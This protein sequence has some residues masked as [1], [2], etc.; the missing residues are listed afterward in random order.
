M[1]LSVSLKT[2]TLTTDLWV[3]SNAVV[4]Q[5]IQRLGLDSLF[6]IASLTDFDLLELICNSNWLSAL[7][8]GAS[9]F[10]IQF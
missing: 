1:K 2:D 4:D 10:K 3:K 7:G 6:L 5:Y 8:K 9:K